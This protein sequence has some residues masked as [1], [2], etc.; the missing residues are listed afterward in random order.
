MGGKTIR[1]EYPI[2]W[3]LQTIRLLTYQL[4]TLTFLR[5]P[6]QTLNNETATHYVYVVL[7]T[8]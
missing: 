1:L 3:S 2:N 6:N 4:D 8:Y 5:G 7:T